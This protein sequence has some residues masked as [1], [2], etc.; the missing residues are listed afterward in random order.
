[1]L[2]TETL[3]SLSSRER[4]AFVRFYVRGL[5]VEAV[6]GAMGLSVSRTREILTKTKAQ[7]SRAL[8]RG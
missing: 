4:L 8:G 7:V 1:M 3:S 5:P 6:A 2:L